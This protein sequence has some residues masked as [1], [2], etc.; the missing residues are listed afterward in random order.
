[1]NLTI[2]QMSL[3]KNNQNFGSIRRVD[4][5]GLGD[6]H[7]AIEIVTNFICS[8]PVRDYA[9]NH[10]LFITTIS[11]RVAIADPKRKY[12]LIYTFERRTYTVDIE[13]KTAKLIMQFKKDFPIRKYNKK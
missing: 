10:D 9:R 12:P 5:K 11:G 2:N 1:M 8:K 3:N 13:K 7:N 6:K 4:L